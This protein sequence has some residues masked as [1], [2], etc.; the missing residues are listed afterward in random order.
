[1]FA[2][3]SVCLPS[4]CLV[5][6]SLS[7][8]LPVCLPICLPVCLPACLRVCLFV[9]LLSHQSINQPINQSIYL[10]FYLW[11]VLSFPRSIYLSWSQYLSESAYL[12]SSVSLSPYPIQPIYVSIYLT[13]LSILY[14]IHSIPNSTYIYLSSNH[15]HQ[16]TTHSHHQPQHCITLMTTAIIIIIIITTMKAWIKF[17]IFGYAPSPQLLTDGTTLT[18]Y[19]LFLKKIYCDYDYDTCPD[20]Q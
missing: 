5:C 19:M 11:M 13:Y 17:W 3:L 6:L 7:A 20:V 10:S 8:C 18:Q 16:K 2:C 4:V 12:S 9:C 15:H 14:L 1:M